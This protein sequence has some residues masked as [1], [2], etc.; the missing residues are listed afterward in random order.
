VSTHRLNICVAEERSRPVLRIGLVL[1]R[2]IGFGGAERYLDA[3]VQ[4][5]VA[6]GCAVCLFATSWATKQDLNGAAL[7]RVPIVRSPRWLKALS[8]AFSTRRQLR[9]FPCDVSMSLDRTLGQDVYRAAGGCHRAWLRARVANAPLF[10]RILLYFNPLHFVF[11]YLEK[12]I[13]DHRHTRRVIALSQQG[14]DEICELY[15]FPRSRIDVIY[16]GVDLECFQP[17]SKIRSDLWF[18][19]L[20][21]GTG[22]ERKGLAFAIRALQYLPHC[23]RLSVYGKDRVSPYFALAR[24]CGVEKR[25][26]FCGVTSEM[27]TVYRQSHLLV[28]PAI[29]EPFG[30]VCLEALASGLPIVVSRATGASEVVTNHVNGAIVDDPANAG[31]LARAISEFLSEERWRNASEAARTEAEKLPFSLNVENTL[32]SLYKASQGTS[33]PTEPIDTT[34]FTSDEPGCG[35]SHSS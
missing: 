12:R 13:F 8:F 4:S 1:E 33:A 23:V 27:P 17:T 29:Y 35:I 32:R 30:N 18:N 22:W 7:H 14:A 9:K 11:L 28:H 6:R 25:V 34:S 10:R 21:V 31:D 16:L 5:L 20:F 3:L 26:T 15:Q 24:N 19:L 2:Y